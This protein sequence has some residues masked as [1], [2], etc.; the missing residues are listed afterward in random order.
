MKSVTMDEAIS[1]VTQANTLPYEEIIQLQQIR[2]QEMIKH[3]RAHSAIYRE[4]YASL[5][6]NPSLEDLP[7]VSK[8]ELSPRMKEWVCDPDF[9]EAEL[10]EYLSDI[11]NLDQPFM[12]KYSVSTT[13]GTTGVPLRMLRDARH[14]TINSA[15]LQVRLYNGPLLKDVA[16]FK[17]REAKYASVLATGGYHA[18]YTGFERVK[19]ALA[20]EGIHDVMELLSIGEPVSQMV[21]RLNRFQPEIITGYPSV[22]EVLSAELLEGRLQI[23]PRAILCSAE[24]LTEHTWQLLTQRFA[25]PVG[26]VFCS[27]EGGEIALLCDQGHMH[28]NMDW[29]ILEPIDKEGKAV[30]PGA[31][32]D[33][34]L[35]TNLMNTVQPII[36]YR[37]DDCIMMH[38]EPCACGLPFPFIDILGRTDDI[39][40]F[41]GAAGSVR[42]SPIVFLN[43]IVDIAGIA[44]FQFAQPSPTAL[45]MRVLYLDNADTETVNQQIGQAVKAELEN[46]GLNN[47]TF[48][49]KN[50]KPSR[51]I[52]GQKMRSYIREF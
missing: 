40:E 2:L 41:A 9:S 7:A 8:Q 27:T 28:V 11:A 31:M 21:S 42:L 10:T 3:A 52:K 5:P 23:E 24:Q 37:V 38:H 1:L 12:G 35:V 14:V 26:N 30:Q 46:Q 49:I 47:I 32:S 34:V 39:P 18:A 29:I 6:E 20:Q 50:E 44:I 4:K 33:A 16:E 19:K 15:L 45:L 36:R 25:C 43:A 13:S 48:S 51:G 22:L 17:K